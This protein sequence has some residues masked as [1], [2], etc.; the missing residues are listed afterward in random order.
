M[1]KYIE[2]IDYK[3]KDKDNIVINYL[4]DRDYFNNIFKELTNELIIFYSD[5]HGYIK[6]MYDYILYNVLTREQRQFNI[7]VVRMPDYIT[8]NACRIYFLNNSINTHIKSFKH[9]YD[10][11]PKYIISNYACDLHIKKELD[12]LKYKKIL[13]SDSH[14]FKL[15]N[16]VSLKEDINKFIRMSKLKNLF[17]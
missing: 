1:T 8:Y 10:I 9:L 5:S 15:K 4:N 12:K 17:V 2:F 3:L 16:E 14:L 13:L 11:E 7:N 6:N